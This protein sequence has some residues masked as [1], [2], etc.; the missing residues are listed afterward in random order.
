M[1]HE[2]IKKPCYT[3]DEG[4]GESEKGRLLTSLTRLER[5]RKGG[6]PGFA[7][8]RGWGQGEGLHAQSG[9]VWS[10]RPAGTEGDLGFFV[11]LPFW[12]SRRG[13]SG[14]GLKAVSCHF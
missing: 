12:S 4:L 3:D 9:L 7:V 14:W 5:T 2:G 8:G 6:W 11:D 10:E 1:K 13:R